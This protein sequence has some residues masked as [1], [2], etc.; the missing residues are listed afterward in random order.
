MSIDEVHITEALGRYA[1]GVV[2]SSTDLDRMQDDLHRRLKPA[3]NRRWRLVGAVAAALLLIAAIAGG[4]WWL[5]KP[6]DPVPV[7]PPSNGSLTGLWKFTNPLTSSVFV[8]RADGS[9]TDYPD[10]TTLV[11][12]L[13]N[14]SSRVIDEGQ[15][16]RVVFSDPQGRPCQS[17]A[18][19]LERRDGFIAQGVQTL[20]GLGCFDTTQPAS[21]ITRL[22]PASEAARDLPA[23]KEGPVTSITDPVQL[24]GVW[25]VEGTGVVVAMDERTG[26]AAFKLDDKGF[27]GAAPKGEGS[28]SIGSNG[29]VALA[30]TRCGTL[31]LQRPEL[32]GQTVGQTLTTTMVADPCRWFEGRSVMTWVR[33][34]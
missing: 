17:E 8:L 2:M 20:T 3:P 24:N 13:T 26:P 1:N 27:V 5:R 18:A 4:A 9:V 19:V 15:R 7:T 11:R 28:I 14:V 22:S 29:D 10:A 33:V 6:A 31:Q 16:I 32:R 21:T 23:T 12:N 25:L 34:L 30:D